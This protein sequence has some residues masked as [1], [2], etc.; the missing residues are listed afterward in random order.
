MTICLSDMLSKPAIF[1]FLWKR[2][3]LPPVIS[4]TTENLVLQQPTIFLFLLSYLVWEN[5]S[6]EDSVIK[7]SFLVGR[8]VLSSLID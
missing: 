8:G 3:L 6:K 5:I 7:A 2:G 1:I 4:Q